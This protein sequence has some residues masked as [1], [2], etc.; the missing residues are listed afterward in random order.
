MNHSS[1][2]G[3]WIVF[4]LLVFSS[5]SWLLSFLH[6]LRLVLLSSPL[7]SSSLFFAPFGPFFLLFSL[8]FLFYFSILFSHL[9]QLLTKTLK[10]NSY[11]SFKIIF[12]HP[13]IISFWCFILSFSSI[14]SCTP[15]YKGSLD[16][17]HWKRK[18]II[19]SE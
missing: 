7:L 11:H 4:L 10:G 17:L 18:F 15:P 3:Y 8:S 2:V 6:S 9:L 16:L 14:S 12:F 19:R 1:E 13:L 5:F